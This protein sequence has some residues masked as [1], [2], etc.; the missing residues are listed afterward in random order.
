MVGSEPPLAWSG[1]VTYL[2]DNL[3]PTHL[4]LGARGIVIKAA[5]ASLGSEPGTLI[6]LDPGSLVCEHDINDNNKLQTI[7]ILKW[8]QRCLH[9]GDVSNYEVIMCYKDY[10]YQVDTSSLHPSLRAPAATPDGLL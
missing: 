8:A 7:R 5:S 2:I 4:V 9:N 6:A 1:N 10:I 3:A